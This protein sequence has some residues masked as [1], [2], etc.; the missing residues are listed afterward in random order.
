MET[1]TDTT[2]GQVLK[3]CAKAIARSKKTPSSSGS[4]NADVDQPCS[5]THSPAVEPVAA[6]SAY[7]T[8]N[9]NIK[10][11]VEEI[12]P[13]VTA[14]VPTTQPPIPTISNETV[15]PPDQ[16]ADVRPSNWTG[17]YAAIQNEPIDPIQLGKDIYEETKGDV[18]KYKCI[19]NGLSGHPFRVDLARLYQ[20]RQELVSKLGEDDPIV[21][22]YDFNMGTMVKLDMD[23]RMFNNVAHV[24]NAAIFKETVRSRRIPV[25]YRFSPRRMREMIFFTPIDVE[26]YQ[27]TNSMEVIN[28]ACEAFIS[29]KTSSEE[30][31]KH[32]TQKTLF[33]CV[34]A[35]FLTMM[36]INPAPR[37]GRRVLKPEFYLFMKRILFQSFGLPFQKYLSISVPDLIVGLPPNE[38]PLERAAAVLIVRFASETLGA[39]CDDLEI[40]KRKMPTVLDEDSDG[41]SYTPEQEVQRKHNKKASILRKKRRSLSSSD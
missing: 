7:E 22:L 32:I 9:F 30:I 38:D 28:W 3:E 21:Q 36:T 17:L 35:Q 40:K 37:S 6:G 2:L 15:A 24:T 16:Y 31:I 14:K 12:D 4:N 20:R 29:E 11:E 26:E 34:K 33:S 19:M 8:F 23:R 25:R 27:N 41:S 10:E 13:Y 1:S 18:N 39:F 5:S